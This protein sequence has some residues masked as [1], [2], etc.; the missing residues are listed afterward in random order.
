[1]LA[2]NEFE[3]L[4]EFNINSV[5]LDDL[6]ELTDITIFTNAPIGERMEFFLDDIKNPYC[7]KVNHI[8]VKISFNNHNNNSLEDC[9]FNHFTSKIDNNTLSW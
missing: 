4:S 7:F 6:K 9:L 5:Y 2:R 8:P 1:M 3:E